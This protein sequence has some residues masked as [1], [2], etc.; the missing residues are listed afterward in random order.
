MDVSIT[1]ATGF[2]GQS[3]VK[4]LA[5]DGHSIK[6]ITRNI[7]KASNILG[8]DFHYYQWEHTTL[9]PPIEAINN[10]DT[11]INLMGETVGGLWLP[12]KKRAISQSRKIG[13]KNLVKAI[14]RA[15]SKPELLISASAVGYYGNR[16]DE[17]LTETSGPGGS[18][19]SE[20][21]KEWE[22][23][24]KSATES[25][26]RVV[27]LRFAPIVGPN[28]GFLDQQ[29]PLAKMG[30]LGPL[31]SGK[32]W[33]PWVHIDDAISAI[34]YVTNNPISGPV[35]VVSPKPIDQITFSKALAGF[36]N[37]QAVLP[38]PSF[39]IRMIL[40]GFADELLF[41]RR[42]IPQKILGAGY[43]FKFVKINEAIK[44]SLK[45]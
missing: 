25:G 5:K 36:Y 19:L 32:Q 27:T 42:V 17:E 30:L 10:S 28:G 34:K 29:L 41:S 13:T 45:H 18:F 23:Q 8:D 26:V 9:E 37:R 11:I 38:A 44:A 24:A 39:A 2:L 14:N 6:I 7:S 20:V 12:S 35:N 1:G 3:L 22:D 4:S 31:G 33:W 43:K 16:G 40:W 15:S 21:C